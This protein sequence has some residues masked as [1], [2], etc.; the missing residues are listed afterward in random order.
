MSLSH[1]SAAR[2]SCF[3]APVD[4]Q[5]ISGRGSYDRKLLWHLVTLSPHTFEQENQEFCIN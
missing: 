3:H 2:E 1:F 5:I 4:A